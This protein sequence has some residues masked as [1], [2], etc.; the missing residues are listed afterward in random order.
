MTDFDSAVLRGTA[1]IAHRLDNPGRWRLLLHA[2]PRRQFV[3]QVI[4]VVDGAPGMLT[5]ELPAGVAPYAAE[6]AEGVVCPGGYLRLQAPVGGEMFVQLTP[7]G[8]DQP[9][10]D[11]RTLQPGDH[12]ICLPLRPGRYRLV[13][14]RSAATADLAIRYPDPRA[15]AAGRSLATEPIRVLAGEVFTPKDLSIDPGQPLA[16]EVAATAHL[17]LTLLD[18]DDGPSDL[19]AWRA[20]HDEQLLQAFQHRTRKQP[21][22]ER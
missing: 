17:V 12:Y 5:V 16:I 20:H 8:C 15:T 21:S 3:R 22:K 9:A 1:I 11:S 18:P 2:P 13:N 14:K 6:V 19:A 4:K 10:W 7:P